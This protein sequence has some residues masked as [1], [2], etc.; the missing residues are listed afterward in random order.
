MLLGVALCARPLAA[1]T[2]SPE[3]TVKRYLQA[4]KDTKFEA[5]YDLISRAMRGGKDRDAFAKEQR[6]GMVWADVKIFSF[7]VG[8]GKVEGDKAFVPNVLSSQDKFVNQLGLTEYE[9]YTLVK[10]DGAWKV[11]QQVIVE[12]PDIPKWFP[13]RKG[14]SG[15]APPAGGPAGS[16]ASSPGSH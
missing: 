16:P 8:T 6:E 9:L 3:E 11:D 13:S 10:E 12:P 4:V 7:E 1:A 14:V 5:A 15:G 2:L